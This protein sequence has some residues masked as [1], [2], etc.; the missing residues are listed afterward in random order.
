MNF[1][2]ASPEGLLNDSILARISLK[3]YAF[4]IQSQND[5]S[6]IFRT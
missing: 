1:F 2:T 3:G 6:A 4:S 5:F